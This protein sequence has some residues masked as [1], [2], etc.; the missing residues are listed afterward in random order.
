MIN[1]VL[2]LGLFLLAI[3][4]TMVLRAITTPAGPST[5]T[6][7]QI[8][9]YGFAGALPTAHRGRARPPG[10]RS[11]IS[12]GRSGAGSAS[13]FSRLRGRTTALGW[14]RPA[15]TRRRPS[16]S[17]ERSSSS[18]RRASHCSGSAHR[19]AGA[20]AWLSSSEPSARPC[21]AG[22]LPTFIVDQ[23]AKKRREQVERGLP[24]SDRPP[25]RDARGRPQ[26]PAVASPRRRRR[27]RSRSRPRFA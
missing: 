27:S 15:C 17:S 5:E 26:L 4:V 7:E 10:A 2:I 21:S 1:L 9:A 3:A 13:R 25:R 6:I 11:A 18:A 16:A 19:A 24:G 14:S 20:A 22:S 23:R 8:G 12:P